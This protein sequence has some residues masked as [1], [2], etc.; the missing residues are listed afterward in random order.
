MQYVGS[1]LLSDGEP[2]SQTLLTLS[3][4]LTI[5]HPKSLKTKYISI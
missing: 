2:S 5:S 1:F 4:L 3:A